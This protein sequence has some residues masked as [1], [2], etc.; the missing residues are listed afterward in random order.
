MKVNICDLDKIQ[1]SHY[2]LFSFQQFGY[3]FAWVCMNVASR[4]PTPECG[5]IQSLHKDS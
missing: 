1:S 3:H 5:H 4:I 2:I